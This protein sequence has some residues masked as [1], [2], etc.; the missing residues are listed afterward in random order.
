[1]Q[2]R[3]GLR[4]IRGRRVRKICFQCLDCLLFSLSIANSALCGFRQGF[5]NNA[6]S[7]LPLRQ[8]GLENVSDQFGFDHQTAL[9]LEQ[10]AVAKRVQIQNPRDKDHQTQQVERDDL[11]RQWR[12]VDRN[13]P[14]PGP[15]FLKD[16]VKIVL[17]R[18][19]VF[20][21]INVSISWGISGRF[22]L[23]LSA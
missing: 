8:L 18:H 1:M 10:K 3:Q 4:E 15:R 19:P 2:V 21:R 5:A 9:A 6:R 20:F 22:A 13:Q 12:T 7:F 11:A 23:L 17:R 16:V 14:A